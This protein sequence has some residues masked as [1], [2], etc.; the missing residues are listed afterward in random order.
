MIDEDDAEVL[1]PLD[2]PLVVDDLVVA[3]HRRV[4][5][6]HH[7]GQCLD[8]HLDPGAESSGCGQQ[9]PLDT[10]IALPVLVSG[11]RRLHGGGGYRR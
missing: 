7:P 4:E 10:G 9:H 11:R 6:A 2:D 1:E 8:G 3:V 5:G